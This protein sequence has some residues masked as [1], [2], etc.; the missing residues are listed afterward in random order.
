[1][2]VRA[3]QVTFH[4][5]SHKG[6]GIVVESEWMTDLEAHAHLHNHQ[7]VRLKC[8]KCDETNEYVP[9]IDDAMIAFWPD[10]RPKK[11]AHALGT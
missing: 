7:V 2:T 10:A 3:Y 4:C 9:A 11:K 1:M 8:G 5:K 6:D